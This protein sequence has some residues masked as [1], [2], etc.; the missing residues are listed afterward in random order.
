MQKVTGLGCAKEKAED[1]CLGSWFR[2]TV[3]SVQTLQREKRL[4]QFPQD[5]FDTIIIDE[6]H[7]ALAAGYQTV[8]EHFCM[9]NVL[10]V[11]A[12]PDRGDRRD[13]GHVFDSLAYEYTL[14]QAI[15]EGYLSPIKALTVPLK[16][17][18]SGVRM[19][20]GDYAAQDVGNALD[21]YLDQIAETIAGQCADRKTV[22]FLP[23]VKT[24]Q[25]MRDILNAHGMN[26]A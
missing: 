2:I 9:A 4:N 13:L 11:T 22:I 15:R 24:A 26:A 8:L 25:K 17:D 1:T 20:N 16:L 14:P 10:G 18:L 3:G 5:Y 21:P 7:H 23:L 6:A 19:Q 12:T